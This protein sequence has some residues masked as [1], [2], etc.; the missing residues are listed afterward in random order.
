MSVQVLHPVDRLLWLLVVA[1]ALVGSVWL[2]SEAY[3][4]FEDSRV[5]TTLLR[6]EKDKYCHFIYKR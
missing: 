1:L 5:V 4:S 2:S 3:V 6:S